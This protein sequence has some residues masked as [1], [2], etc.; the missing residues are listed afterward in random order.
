M[1]LAQSVVE[2]LPERQVT[3]KIEQVQPGRSNIYAEVGDGDGPTL[4][5]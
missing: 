5:L 1:E 4:C 3:A 2:W